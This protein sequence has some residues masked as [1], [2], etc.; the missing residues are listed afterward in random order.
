MSENKN[1]D[2][3]TNLFR[4]ITEEERTYTLNFNYLETCLLVPEFYVKTKTGRGGPL[5]SS[6]E[7]QGLE[8]P[9][10][11]SQRKP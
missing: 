8:K 9:S 11:S 3:G 1:E 4:S 6:R 5:D 7:H 2:R 10:E